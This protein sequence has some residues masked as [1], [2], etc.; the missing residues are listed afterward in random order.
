MSCQYYLKYNLINCNSISLTTHSFEPNLTIYTSGATDTD[1]KLI[2]EIFMVGWFWWVRFSI[3]E[4]LPHYV[5]MVFFYHLDHFRYLFYMTNPG[6]GFNL[7]R[8]VFMRIAVMVKQLN[9]K[10]N[11]NYTLVSYFFTLKLYLKTLLTFVLI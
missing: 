2:W 10:S 3:F 9:E 11:K 7:R 4:E 8:D 5:S 6:E 1:F